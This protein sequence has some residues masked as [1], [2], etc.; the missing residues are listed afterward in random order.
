MPT[1]PDIPTVMA[2]CSVVTLVL[3]FGLLLVHL[4]SRTYPGFPQWVVASFCVSVSTILLTVRE[5]LPAGLTTILI[6]LT[7]FLY[8]LLLARGFRLFLGLPPKNWLAY[9]ALSAV[10]VIA[11]VFNYVRP[12]PSLRVFLLSLILAPL[13]A[14]SAWLVRRVRN[15]APPAVK[16]SLIGAFSLL[17]AWNLLRSPVTAAIQGWNSGLPPSPIVLSVTQV[18]LTTTHIVTALALIQLNY[19][20]ASESLRESEERFQSA[21]QQAPIGMALVATDGRWLEVNP[22]LCAIV[23][24]TRE[25]LLGRS[26]Q[27]ITHPEDLLT[28]EQSMGRLLMREV[29]TYR[30]EKRYLHKEARPVWVN[31]H[32]SPIFHPDGTVRHLVSQIIDVTDRKRT[33]QALREYQTRLMQAMDATKLGHW[34]FNLETERFTFDENF[35]KLL[36]TSVAAEGSFEMRAADYERRFLPAD[37]VSRLQQVTNQAIAAADPGHTT[38]I[39]HRFLRT[40]G[41]TGVMSVRFAIGRNAGGRAVR[42]FGLS[43]DITEQ[44]RAEQQ[45]R[46]LEEQLRHAQK[47]DALGTLAGGIAHDFNNILTGI[48]G[49]LDLAAMDLPPTHAVQPRLQ[50]AQQASRRARDHIARILTFSRRYQGDRT[51]KFLGPVVQEAV[52]LLRASLP[53]T[54]EIQAKLAPNCPAVLCDTAQIHQII[55]NLGTN[56]AHAMRTRGGVLSIELEPV[57]PDRLLMDRHPQ[58]KA[59]HQVRLTVRDTGSGIDPRVL[60]RIFE[61]F[62]TTKAPDEGTGLGLAMVHGIVEDHQGAIVV[63]SVVGQGTAVAVYLPATAGTGAV[64]FSPAAVTPAPVQLL[65]RGRKILIVDDDTT[66][67]RLGTE[68][69]SLSGFLPDPFSNPLAALKKFEGATAEYAAIVSDLTMPGITGVELARRCRQIRPDVPFVLASG[70]LHAEAQGG[71]QESGVSHFINKP[72]DIGEFVAKLRAALGE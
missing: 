34:E 23:G 64:S 66:V 40:D 50:D 72:F 59:S 6:N 37:E 63:T 5:W 58:V 33:E 47:M 24:Y 53:V 21:M 56:A 60:A 31:V 18:L 36:G 20:R 12:D 44:A 2:M 46:M 48:M 70:Y 67:L 38:E 41:S 51:A 4:T 15:F 16:W 25:E 27:S 65:G 68:I 61:P 54:I 1:F 19:A 14:D 26:S 43:Q 32:V 69:L 8:P 71:A 22:A 49:N 30:R 55:M 13:F 45:H 3:S 10:M 7:F 52:Q 35:Y 62:F 42:A 39:E 9:A 29:P 11:I 28:D 57:T 17:S